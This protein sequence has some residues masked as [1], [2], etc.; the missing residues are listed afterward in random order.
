M[1]LYDIAY[2]AHTQEILVPLS[3]AGEALRNLYA[4]CCS[5]ELGR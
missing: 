3:Y 1:L 2:L 5:A 4:I